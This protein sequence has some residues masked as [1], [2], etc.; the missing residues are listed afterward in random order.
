MA[1]TIE[2]V[3]AAADVAVQ[4]VYYVFGTKRN[5]LGAVLDAQIA[6]DLDTTPL[7]DRPWIDALAQAPD[8]S[9]AVDILVE[10]AVAII[11]RAS[12]MYE[13]VRRAAADPEVGDLLAANR[14]ARR[15]DQRRLVE[16]LSHS[17]QL[18]RGLDVDEF[19]DVVY[20]VLNEEIYQLLIV[21]CGWDIQRFREW[22]T[23]L[24]LQQLTTDDRP[25]RRSG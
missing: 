8:A 16:I 10:S 13:V 18:P 4:T 6:G 11:A 15:A 2:A 19:A 9:S 20:A 3:A 12:P 17:S 5:L 21:D 25:R 14:R 22:A 1:T 23:S 24:L 7:V